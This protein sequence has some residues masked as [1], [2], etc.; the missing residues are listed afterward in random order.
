MIK[1]GLA[2]A[3][4]GLA[5]TGASAAKENVVRDRVQSLVSNV[6]AAP[7]DV[8]KISVIDDSINM[9]KTIKSVLTIAGAPARALSGKKRQ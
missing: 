7:S 8:K 9:V 4:L 3:A 2:L 6:K 1:A 5:A